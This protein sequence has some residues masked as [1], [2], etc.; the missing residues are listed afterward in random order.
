MITDEYQRMMS[1]MEMRSVM[2]GSNDFGEELELLL[3]EQR[4]QLEEANNRERELNIY[5]SGSAPPTIKGSLEAFGGVSPGADL[6]G[7][8]EEELRANAA[9][10]S[11]YYSNGNI[12]PRLPPPLLS[13][14]D[15]RSAQRLQ[16]GGGINGG[17]GCGGSQVRLG[18]IGDRRKVSRGGEGGVVETSQIS[19]RMGFAGKNQENGTEAQKDWGGNGLIGLPG[20]GLGSQQKSIAEIVQVKRRFKYFKVLILV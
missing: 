8:S 10:V 14:E 5:R 7:V 11:Y 19:K 2:G 15:W 17:G 18:G 16:G 12:N 9:Y 6:N 1:D 13:K 3:R 4:R 20:L